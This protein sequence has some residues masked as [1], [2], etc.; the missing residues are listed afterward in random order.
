MLLFDRYGRPLLNLRVAVTPA[1]DQNCFYCHREGHYPPT[2][3][4]TVEEIARMVKVAVE[5]GVKDVKITGGEPLM[6]QD[7]TGLVEELRKIA[8]LKEI[9][10]VTNAKLL[11]EELALKLK[12]A[13]LSRVNINLPSL[14]PTVY[15]RITG[16]RIDG[17]LRG[18]KAAI[19]AGLTPVKLNMVLLKGLNDS[20]VDSM[21]EASRKLGATLQLIELEPI[22]IS[23]GEYRLYH[24]SLNE[25]E[26]RLARR[27]ERIEPRPLMHNRKVYTVDG[28]RVEVVKPIENTEFC[29]H[30]TRMRLTSDGKLKPCLMREDN[31]VDAL[32][33][34]R[35]GVPD[36][37]LKSLFLKANERREPFYKPTS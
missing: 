28:A 19:N 15:E 1:C 3:T 14:N 36:E 4:M 18:V 7:I 22:N 9:S 13:G 24:T 33:P 8:S 34:L 11:T 30:C 37:V 31:L 32:S 2:V 6:R 25:V 29:A 17:A 5:F 16:G 35:R 12:E 27:A 21:M 10:M 20:E 23:T 26:E